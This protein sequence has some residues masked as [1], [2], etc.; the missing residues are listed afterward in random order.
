[1]GAGTWVALDELI[2]ANTDGYHI[3]F[4][5]KPHIMAGYLNPEMGRDNSLDDFTFLA[6]QVT[7]PSTISIRPDDDRFDDLESLVEYAQENTLTTTST[8]VASQDHTAALMFNQEH[9]TNFE[10]VQTDGAAESLTQVR[11]G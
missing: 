11:G 2:T 6:N 1:P 9:G 7:S 4:V 10:A 5:N 8:G 3:G